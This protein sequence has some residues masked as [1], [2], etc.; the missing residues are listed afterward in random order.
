MKVRTLILCVTSFFAAIWLG[1][2]VVGFELTGTSWSNKRATMYSTGGISNATFDSAFVQA[3]YQW[4]GLSSFTYNK[5]GGFKDPCANP[6]NY[7]PPWFSG[8][9]FDD[10]NCGIGFG[11]GTLAVTHKWSSGSTIIQAGIVFNTRFSWDVHSG[12]S[13]AFIDFRR[14]ATHEL[15]HVLGLGHDN[16]H[17]ALMN[18][19]YSEIIE[20]PQ[21]D[22]INGIRAIYGGTGS[23]I[24]LRA[25]NGQY[26]VAEGGGGGLVYANRNAIG[27]WEKFDLI[28]LGNNKFALRA[29][30]GQYV[31]AE[32]GGGGLVYAN[33]NGVGPWETFELVEFGNNRIALKA[34]NG[35]FV[36][37]EGSGGDLVYANRNSAGPWEIF[38]RID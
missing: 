12:S 13:D 34:N 10:D 24:A 37:A 3:L 35:Q 7:G 26:L 20:I 17:L 28:D 21:D 5:A 36:V 29:H 25:S 33:R 19:T 38:V 4:N 18:T 15:G 30:N 31:V 16:T 27:P 2:E 6:N 8:W 11:S 23:S 9:S 32:G 1:N 22:D 14:V